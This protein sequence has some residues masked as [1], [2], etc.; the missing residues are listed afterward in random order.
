MGLYQ[1]LALLNTEKL[2]QHASQS[3]PQQQMQPPQQQPQASSPM[4]AAQLQ[5]MSMNL[6]ATLPMPAVASM[7]SAVSALS[8][9]VE[10]DS[11]AAVASSER[12][13]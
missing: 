2:Q 7:S 3:Q 1:Q 6:A 12:Q 9:F 8:R 4:Q 10:C 13:V 11:D 5:A